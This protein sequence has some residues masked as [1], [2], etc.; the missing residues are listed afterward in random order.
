MLPPRRGRRR[1][2]YESESGGGEMSTTLARTVALAA[3]ALFATGSSSNAQTCT[4]GANDVRFVAPANGTLDVARFPVVSIGFT[5]PIPADPVALADCIRIL[6]RVGNPVELL[7]RRSAHDPTVALASPLTRE[8]RL[9]P[10]SD[11]ILEV[12]LGAA[13]SAEVLRTRF[14]TGGLKSVFCIQRAGAEPWTN[15]CD[16]SYWLEDPAIGGHIVR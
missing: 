13:D 15:S 8:D 3:A 6:D 9:E 2:W 16:E 7:V 10:A 1:I 5:D 12:S 4:A 14:R 11:Y